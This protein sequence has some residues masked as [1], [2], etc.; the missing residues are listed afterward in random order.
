MRLKHVLFSG[1]LLS[2]GLTACTN[3]DFT[4]VQT[5]E[6]NTDNAISLGD[7]TITGTKGAADT[8]AFVTDD[9][10]KAM[11]EKTDTIGA[12]WY[13][14]IYS[15]NDNGTVKDHQGFN[16]YGL[17]ASNTWFKFQE[18]V[19]N[20][21]SSATFHSDANLMAGTYVLYYPYDP[22]VTTSFAGIPVSID[23]KQEM[24]CT[25][26]NELASVNKNMFAYTI[27]PFVKGGDQTTEFHLGQLTNVFSIKFQ[28]V[29][30][31][32]MLL[33]KP[34]NISQVIIR[35]TK[36]GESVLSTKGNINV[37]TGGVNYA[38]EEYGKTAYEDDKAAS[39]ANHLLLDVKNADEKDYAL[40]ALETPTVKPFYI[41]AL[42]FSEDADKITVEILTADNKVYSKTY[43]GTSD[44]LAKINKQATGEGA[45]IDLTVT[46]DNLNDEGTIYNAEQ[47]EEQWNAVL[48]GTKKGALKVAE[49]VDLSKTDLKLDKNVAMTIEN[50]GGSG[51]VKLGS[52]DLTN[53]TLT[54]NAPTTVTGDVT[55]GPNV[56]GFSGNA[57][58]TI[59]GTLTVNGGDASNVDLK[60]AKVGKV[61][62]A[63]SGVATLEGDANAAL[64]DVT[65]EGKLTLSNIAIA[66]NGTLNNTTDGTVVLGDGNV[67]NNGTINNNGEFN[68]NK[69]TFANNGKFE[70][71]GTITTAGTFNN[72]A[73][74]TLNVDAATSNVKIVNAGKSTN[75]DAAIITVAKDAT[76]TAS[77]TT[78]SIENNGIITVN[79]TLAESKA[80]SLKQSDDD[81]RIYVNG[82]LT[83]KDDTASGITKGFVIAGVESGTINGGKNSGKMG[84]TVATVAGLEAATQTNLFVDCK[85]GLTIEKN[86]IKASHNYYFMSGTV[87]VAEDVDFSGSSMLIAGD[88]TLVGSQAV[89]VKLYN[90]QKTNNQILAGGKLTLGKNITLT[91]NE[92]TTL[93]IKEG[94]EYVR[95]G[96]VIGENVTVSYE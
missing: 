51:S 39:N 58:V 34:V 78:N 23:N 59:D 69:K 38:T 11:W 73:G 75:K 54:V 15:F 68:L 42:P 14:M 4:T 74:A 72:N 32:L 12:A 56:K 93:L 65:N 28:V 87:T 67:K 44:V 76:L 50:E 8:R 60:V 26:G 85:N 22:A 27:V 21:M 80:G 40:L 16:D 95:N 79:G 13:D 41:S 10:K 7:V 61:E 1:L 20:D 55:V 17:F 33:E 89:T 86:A 71:N 81:A 45:K 52:L 91:A 2:V 30:P 92:A 9:L 64:S 5:P 66:A 19:G 62:I 83:F 57:A 49:A 90:Y 36:D 29:K 70:Q 88:V 82:T 43:S 63:A 53:G 84:K 96:G 31:D 35:A 94:G 47:F 37:P 25:E 3:D 77:S 6:V 48:A 46:L 24:D 18:Q